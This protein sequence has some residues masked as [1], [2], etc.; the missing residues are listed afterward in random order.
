MKKRGI[1]V[2]TYFLLLALLLS[3][4]ASTE[5]A[6]NKPTT[7]PDLVGLKVEAAKK[8]LIKLGLTENQIE[9]QSNQIFNE[10][11]ILDFIV[12]GHWPK[13]GSPM[14]SKVILNGNTECGQNEFSVLAPTFISA[15]CEPA[16]FLTYG[17]R[18]FSSFDEI[19]NNDYEI[20]Y[21][22][23]FYL[24]RDSYDEFTPAE[25]EALQILNPNQVLED[26][27]SNK[28]VKQLKNLY[29]GCSY[30][31]V[32][33]YGLGLFDLENTFTRRDILAILK[34]CPMNPTKVALE[35]A[36]EVGK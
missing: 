1:F 5:T 12:C 36:V 29:V 22:D 33:N 19:W 25:I 7:M 35:D 24:S 20:N 27:G 30:R 18:I 13:A 17:S 9:S 6:L 8:K 2:S 4:C 32:P 21:C 28:M 16:D 23:D 3:S 15:N 26:L 14:P 11:S 31:Y 10:V 34:L